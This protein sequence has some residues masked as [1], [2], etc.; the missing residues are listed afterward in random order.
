MIERCFIFE[1]EDIIHKNTL[2]K[3]LELCKSSPKEMKKENFSSS[4]EDSSEKHAEQLDFQTMKENFEKNF[5]EAALQ[6][7]LGKI[8]QTALRTNIPKVTLLRKIAKYAINPKK[9]IKS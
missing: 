7:N 2:I 5:L 3:N 1:K 4:Q 6:S 8:N 9:Y